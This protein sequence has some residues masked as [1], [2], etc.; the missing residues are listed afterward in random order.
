MRGL[1]DW[2]NSVYVIACAPALVALLLRVPGDGDCF[3]AICRIGTAPAPLCPRCPGGARLPAARPEGIAR[4]GIRRAALDGG[5]SAASVPTRAAVWMAALKPARRD[6]WAGRAAGR[7]KHKAPPTHQVARPQHRHV[8][9][10]R[11]V[12]A[13][14]RGRARA[15]RNRRFYADRRTRPDGRVQTL[16]AGRLGRACCRPP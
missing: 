16:V 6:G 14:L 15:P 12:G 10:R 3:F 11:A 8:A 2:L 1:V 7:R 9:L 5:A 13:R 4:T